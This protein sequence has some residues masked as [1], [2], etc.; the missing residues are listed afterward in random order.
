MVRAIQIGAVGGP[1]VLKSQSVDIGLPGPGEVRL[2]HTAVGVNYIDVY[3]RT[4]LYSAP[5]PFIPGMEAA[6]VVEA[7]GPDVESLKV[8]DRVSYAGALGSYS[9]ARIINAD[10]LISLPENVS[11]DLAAAITLK[12][13]TAQVLLRQVY[14]VKSGDTILIHAAAG[15]LGLLMTQWAKAL[16]A[17]VIGTV[18]S[19]D[20]AAIAREHGCDH[21]IVYT[22][23]NFVSRVREITDGKKLPVVFDSVGKDTFLGSLDCL[24]PHGLMVV[25]GASSGPVP[26]IQVSQLAQRGSLF[27]T[28]AVV[29]NYTATRADLEAAAADLFAIV[30]SGKVR[31]S[32]NQRYELAQAE[33]AHRELE[34]R[35]T[36]GA[37]IL[38]L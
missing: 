4:G 3:Y 29:F 27:L 25:S 17:I 35:K 15:G 16:G 14:K 32:V 30:G 34:N 38:S 33:T 12:G 2:R 11:N 24:Q 19:E 5:L 20:K 22:R 1:E 31:V 18:S 6:G 8:G 28:R 36:T 26:P 10:R 13:L 37:T 21:P 23:E 9:E 7:L